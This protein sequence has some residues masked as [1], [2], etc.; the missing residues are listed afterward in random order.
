MG[1]LGW[2]FHIRPLITGPHP[3]LT[4][5]GEAPAD[6]NHRTGGATTT[7]HRCWP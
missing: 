5:V 4:V 2:W 1:D 3:L 7:R 6:F